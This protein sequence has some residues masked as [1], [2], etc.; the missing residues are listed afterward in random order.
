M[1][2]E[3]SIKGKIA[4]RSPSNLAIVKYW[5]KYGRQLPRNASISLT[6]SAAYT[7]MKMEYEVNLE[8]SEL[9]V[10][11]MFEGKPQL[12]FAQ[13][14]KAF[15]LSIKDE[16][17]FLNHAFLK[18]E[19]SNSF[20]HSS[21][22]ASSASSMSALALCICSI[23]RS[24]FEE[25]MTDTEFY[26]RASHFA[27]LG[28]GSASRSV[29]P[30]M[31]AWGEHPDIDASSNE[32]AVAYDKIAPVFKTFHDDILIVSARE[33]SVSSTA[34]HQLMEGNPY[35]AARYEQANQ[36]MSILLDALEKGDVLAFGKIAEDEAMTL[37]GMMMCSEPSYMLMEANTIEMIRR[38]Q[39]YRN[40]TGVPVFF[41][42]DAGPNIHLLYPDEVAPMVDLLIKDQLKE[43][44]I[45]GRVIKDQ[46]GTGPNLLDF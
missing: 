16:L 8:Q 39:S 31:A 40:E 2:K 25:G 1:L 45:D 43:L 10:D 7:D 32:Y 15:L 17:P 12:Q 9:E 26:M 24:H 22:I 29:Y 11:F 41:S 36:R 4:W 42:L 37:H 6:L 35:A 30:F 34:G 28:S 3:T 13:K 19:S 33:K 46:V 14:I 27:R 44:C 5:G 21:G 18:I 20:P 38:I 23:H